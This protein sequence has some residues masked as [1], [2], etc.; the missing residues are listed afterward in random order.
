VQLPEKNHESGPGPNGLRD[1]VLRAG[2]DLFAA[3]GVRFSPVA[4]DDD[5]VH[6]S[7]T[8]PPVLFLGVCG[9]GGTTFTGHVV[10]GASEN[11]LSRSNNTRS[12]S[13]DW[14]AE[15]ANQFLGR[16]KNG[17]L[18]QGIHVHRVP[19]VVIK[20]AAVALAHGDSAAPL[21]LA[22]GRDRVLIWI[23]TEPSTEGASAAPEPA[24][25]VLSEGEMVLF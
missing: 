9:F 19:P 22:D 10:F 18:R 14:M 21:A 5:P 1:E 15:L 6:I 4:V 2:L 7:G 24:M 11:V 13:A 3:Y 25:D 16:I 8:S 23:D 20:G 12:T 17:L